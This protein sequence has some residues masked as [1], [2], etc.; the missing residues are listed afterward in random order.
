MSKF[1]PSNSTTFLYYFGSSTLITIVLASLVLHLSPTSGLPNQLGLVMGL[2]G[3]LVGTY[4]NRSITL[5]KDS[6]P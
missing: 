5:A 3:G 1:G 2:F 6:G 4:F